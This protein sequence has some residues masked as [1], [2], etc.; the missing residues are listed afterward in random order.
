MAMG[1]ASDPALRGT[2]D[3]AEDLLKIVAPAWTVQRRFSLDT[4]PS[5]RDEHEEDER[6]HPTSGGPAGR[7]DPDRDDGRVRRRQRRVRRASPSTTAG[8][9][10]EP[11]IDPGDG[12]DYAPEL[13]PADFVAGV[14]HPFLPLA[15]GNR[16]VYEETGE[17]GEVER[18]EV[19]VQEET[20]EIAGISATVVRDTVTLDGVLVEDTFDWFAQDR[21][22]NVWYLGEDVDNY[23]DG[24]LVD[25]DGSFQHGQDG[26][27]AGIV[28]PAEPQVGDA[29]RQEYS[30]G[31]AEDLGEVLRLDGTAS[32]PFGE[33][34]D[35]LVTRDWNPLEPEVVEEKSY[36]R[37][38]GLVHEAKVRGEAGEAVLIEADLAA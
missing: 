17:D 14:D 9:T 6:A 2:A 29:Y 32:V 10:V 28:M 36:A 3:E 19:V 7:L 24:R 21:E 34:D 12:G 8:P 5:P 4:P 33:L 35:L 25:H 26:A 37:G 18:I 30:P 16:W 27:Y 31:E 11:V 38:I 22:G 15:P 23:E 20:R 13:D 1:R